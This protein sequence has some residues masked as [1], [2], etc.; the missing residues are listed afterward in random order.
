MLLS[1]HTKTL[2]DIFASK[3][4]PLTT[5]VVLASRI[6]LTSSILDRYIEELGGNSSFQAWF[7]A[8][9][10]AKRFS[11][12]STAL[13]PQKVQNVDVMCE[14]YATASYF[15]GS[16]IFAEESHF[17]AATVDA[18]KN[19][20]AELISAKNPISGGF[21]GDNPFF[22]IAISTG[23]SED[24]SVFDKFIKGEDR[25]VVYDKYINE[26]SVQLLIHLAETLSPNSELTIF[27]AEKRQTRLLTTAQIISRVQAASPHVRVVC[28]KCSPAFISREHDRYIFLGT[29]IQIVFTVGL[30]CFGQYDLNSGARNNRSSKIL[31]F[32]VAQSPFL[33]IEADDMTVCSVRHVIEIS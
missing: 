3:C 19:V 15:G 16:N 6:S 22:T 31:F 27:H 17:H 23:G 32:D 29:R 20:G 1:V 11:V 9:M 2:G 33:K 4:D 30:D 8:S 28:K 14:N 25:V 18:L 26:C 10:A 24:F 13:A 12:N 5:N 7:S 21:C